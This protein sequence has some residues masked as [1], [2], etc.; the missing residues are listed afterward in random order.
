MASSGASRSVSPHG[1]LLL[2]THLLIF[3]LPNSAAQSVRNGSEVDLLALLFFK[4]DITNDPRGVLASWN[5]SV[6]FCG[7]R[8]VTCGT[9]LPPRVV[10][11][12][13]ISANLDGP[14]S[15]W[16]ANLTSLERLDLSYNSLSGVIHEELG[17]L[18][19]LQ[20]LNLSAN[21]LEGIIP[22]SVG[23][24][25]SLRYVDLSKNRLVGT[26]PNF[27]KMSALQILDLSINN[28]TGSIPSS[29][30]NVSSLTEIFLYS[31]SLS[32]SVPETLSFIQNLTVL[33][34][35]ENYLS[36]HVSAKLC[37]ISSLVYLLLAQ[38]NFTGGIPSNIGNTLQNLEGLSMS[39]N[40]LEGLIPS[41]LANASNLLFID[42]GNNS[43]TGPVP[44]LGSLSYLLSI[45]LGNNQISGTIPVEIFNLR[46]LQILSM[47]RNLLSGVI[48]SIIR[49]LDQL[50]ILTLSGNKFYGQIPSTIGNLSRLNKLYLDSND[51]TGNIPGSLGKCKQLNMLEMSFNSLQGPIPSQLLN[52]TSLSL[53]LDLSN[54]NLTGSIPHEIGALIQLVH[55]DISANKLSGQV[56]VSLGQCVQLVFLSLRSN[57]LNGSIPVSFSNLKSIGQIDLSQN[58]LNGTIPSF[59]ANMG[60]LQLLDLSMNFFE[61]AI[62]T[63]GIFQNHSAV[64]LDGNAGLCGGATTNLF[65]FPVCTTASTVE[66]KT[67]ALLLAK[68][69]P[70]IAIALISF[71]FF[72]V[73]LLKRS[74]AQA[75][76]CY[77]ATMKKVSYGGIVKATN[78]FSPVNKI[79]SS[80]TGSIYIGRF[81][82]D[83]DLVAIKLFHLEENGARR[84]FLTECE[85]LRNT[86]HRNLVKAVTVCSTVDLENNEF[87]AIVFDFMANGSLDMWLHPKLHQNFPKRVL[88]FGQRLSIATDVALALDY[89]HNQLTPPLIHCDLK[90]GNVLLDYDMTARVGDFGSARFL[91]SIPGNSEDLVGVEGTI[92][93]VAPESQQDAMSMVSG[94]CF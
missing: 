32:G 88:S 33:D 9:A 78:W 20:S 87:K 65:Q 24:S 47:E 31:N 12:N 16:I 61:G 4:R 5:A 58:Y 86:R 59:F 80:R 13:L 53:G 72:M 50:V 67:N 36:G 3:L 94:S 89:M 1:T 37:N 70:P 40:R 92:G 6:G 69:I 44:S 57:M 84:S 52:S 68:V 83:T 19:H 26:V 51:F 79:S 35:G 42:L 8:G 39:S 18:P 75:G 23:I 63:N 25:R 7:W 46:Y 48:P 2:F 91:S 21:N 43:L 41:S 76:P 64:I 55:L 45:N 77:N 17:T 14:L 10:S 34:L 27:H 15:P 54:N 30:G 49:N 90:P 66:S 74:E 29:L 11:L 85:V 56:P 60:Y 28:L 93:Y 38:N 73:T 22:R 71:V 82:F 81:E 62:P